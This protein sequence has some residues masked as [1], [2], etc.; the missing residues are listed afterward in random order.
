MATVYAMQHNVTKRIYVG[1]CNV[2]EYRIKKHLHDLLRGAHT[3]TEL[4][5]DFDKYGMEF[6]FYVL[7]YVEEKDRM[8]AE[9][10]WQNALRSND[11]QTGYNLSLQEKPITDLSKFERVY[12]NCIRGAL[13]EYF[14]EEG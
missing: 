4:Q 12:L 8:K 13:T 7:E 3:N 14:N 11:I 9:R 2:A 1:V 6:S 10:S 5:K